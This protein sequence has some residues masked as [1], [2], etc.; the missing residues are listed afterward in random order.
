MQLAN[1]EGP[2]VLAFPTP[3]FRRRWPDSAEL[4]AGLRELVLARRAKTPSTARSN[5]GGW[6]SSHDLMSWGGPHIA[7]LGQR[8]EE[9]FGAAMEAEIGTRAFTCRLAV[10]AWANANGDGD[11][12]RHH[13]HAGNHWS[14]VYYVDLGEPDPEVV[15]NGA[16]EFLD[17][18]P[19]VGVYDLPNVPTWSTWTVQPQPGE[20]LL[21][22]S[23]LRH[24]VLP[25][26]GA[27][28][29][30]SLAFNLRVADL[31]V[32]R[33]PAGGPAAGPPAGPPGGP[34]A[35]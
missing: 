14:G 32:P 20:M 33:G 22:P 23:W 8:I 11:Y 27:G 35:G 5:V 29:R 18:R 21:F 9:A 7:A 13:T 12:N 28:T 6:Q 3:I 24:G 10:T 31:Q 19:A 30:I 25:F 15:P 16:I 4:N 17:P 26:R 2:V 34:V 1:A